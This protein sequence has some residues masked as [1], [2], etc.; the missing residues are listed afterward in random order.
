[1]NGNIRIDLCVVDG[2]VCVLFVIL[3][4]FFIWK[5]EIFLFRFFSRGSGLLEVGYYSGCL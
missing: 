1:M 2:G 5:L 4:Y 3:C